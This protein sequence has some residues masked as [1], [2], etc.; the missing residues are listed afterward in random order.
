MFYLIDS[1]CH[2]H[3][4]EFFSE[5]QAEA[6][7]K[8]AFKEGVKQI[9]C[10]GTSHKDSMAAKNFAKT[11]KNVFWTY[12]VHPESAGIDKYQDMDEFDPVGIGEIGLDY[13]YP[14]FDRKAQLKLLEEMIELSIKNNLPCSFHVRD[15]LSD[16][17]AVLDNFPNLKT[18]VLHSFSDS[19]K[20]LEKAIEKGLYIGVNGLITFAN[21]DCYKNIDSSILNHI[22]LET[23]APFLTP[24][25]KRGKI[26]EPGNIRYIANYLSNQLQVSEEIVSEKTSKNV[27][28]IFNLPNPGL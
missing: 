10:I 15:A 19:R 7:L 18:S 24:A 6:M 8:T 23:D 27:Q 2:L 5:Q 1:H 12:G 9:I 16:F 3:D 4:R 13:H 20:N 11:H 14:G 21:L 22:I 17:F 26:N 25:P 28:T